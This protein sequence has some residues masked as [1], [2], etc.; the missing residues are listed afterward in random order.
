MSRHG[1][2]RW[3]GYGGNDCWTLVCLSQIQ[4]FLLTSPCF[5]ILMISGR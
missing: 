3:P 5:L 1:N 4:P 2:R